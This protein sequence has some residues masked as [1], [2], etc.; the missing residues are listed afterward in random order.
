MTS[1]IA[2]ELLFLQAEKFIARISTH[3]Q[4]AFILRISILT[5]L[6]IS[7]T[8]AF[9]ITTAKAA[10]ISLTSAVNVDFTGF[11]GA[12]F[13]P[14][15]SAGQLSSNDWAIT[16]FSDGNLP[17]GGTGTSGDFARGTSNG[18]TG[19]GGIYAYNVGGGNFTFGVQP[20]GA[21][22]TP[23]NLTLRLQNTGDTINSLAIIYNIYVRNDGGRANSFNFSYSLDDSAYTAV[24]S[25]NFVSPQALDE[26]P[27]WV[28]TSRSVTITEL[29]LN[30][31]DFFYLRWTG[32]DV[33]GSGFRDSFA[34][35]DIRV[36]AT[37]SSAVP[38][39]FSP[40]LGLLAFAILWGYE[41]LKMNQKSK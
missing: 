26:N 13:S 20:V 11:A 14:N 1:F 22:F 19:T 36:T 12:G 32:N 24:P 31:G 38:L 21:D 3:Q 18:G 2:D 29:T 4:I 33:S 34:L 9:S 40:T 10:N 41:W 8:G 27:S 16:G 6:I 15:P 25:L 17:Y 5:Q 30:N 28:A 23:G 35:D 37:S 39:G 7:L